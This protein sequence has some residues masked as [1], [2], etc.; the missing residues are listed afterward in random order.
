MGKTA[1]DLLTLTGGA[2]GQGLPVAI[3][4]AV[5]CPQRPVLALI[6]DGA[7]VY[8]IQSLWTIAREQLDVTAVILNNR[9]YD[10]LNIELQ[11]VGAD[12]A[13]ERARSQLDLSSP[14]IDFVAIGTGLGVP[15]VRAQTCRELN[16]ALARALAEPGP[17]LIEAVIP[18][19]FTGWKLRALP[20][21]LTALGHLPAVAAKGLKR[22]IAP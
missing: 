13:G 19:S 8:T 15:S 22:R 9:S 10:I 4:A 3:G 6:G 18:R 11:R 14:A 16:D 2:I 12:A 20:H 7:A 1:H 21:V 5:A 17:H